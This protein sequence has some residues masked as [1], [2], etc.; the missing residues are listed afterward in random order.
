[1]VKYTQDD[2]DGEWEFKIVRSD[3]G[4]FR[5]PESLGRLVAEEAEA[6]WI[7]LEKFDNSRVRFKRPRSARSRDPYLASG[8]DPYRSQ[9][10]IPS[11]RYAVMLGIL[12]TVVMLFLGVLV[13]FLMLGK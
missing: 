12:A 13:F 10:G 4:A 5:K 9:Y 3:S 7:L 6:G 2:L 11:A 1:M 8:V